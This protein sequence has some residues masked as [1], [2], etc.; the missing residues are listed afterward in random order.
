M[1]D[2][3][4]VYFDSNVFIYAV[5]GD[6]AISTQIQT[7]LKKARGHPGT[8]ITGEVTLLEVLSPTKGGR[9]RTPNFKRR[10]L[11]LMVWS[12]FIDLQPITRAVIYETVALKSTKVTGKLQFP[13]A[14]HLATA[15][16]SGCTIFLSNDR[17]IPVPQGMKKLLPDASSLESIMEA[18]R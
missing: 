4:A 3:P 17:D 10:Y 11:D 14:I 15:I 5:E 7:M 18:L 16:R 12:R 13:D 8:V 2:R 6:E 1:T 9:K